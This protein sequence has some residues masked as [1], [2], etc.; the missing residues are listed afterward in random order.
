[1]AFLAVGLLASGAQGQVTAR[2]AV[3]RETV[4]ELDSAAVIRI[5][6]GVDQVDGVLRGLIGS[7]MMLATDSAEVTFSVAQLD[8]LWIQS[9]GKRTGGLIGIG[10]G[11]GLTTLSCAQTLDECGLDAGLLII[12]PALAL[13]G[14]GI[15]S[16][17]T[18]WRLLYP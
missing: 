18:R 2:E 15:G 7:R 10:A 9:T 12:T 13:L 6:A 17:I 8:S 5:R 4:A 11:L 14:A 3:L 1:M 16:I